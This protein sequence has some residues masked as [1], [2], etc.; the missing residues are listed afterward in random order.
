MKPLPTAAPASVAFV[1][2]FHAC[3]G[4]TGVLALADF[5][6][7]A[8]YDR[9]VGYYA[10]ARERIGRRAGTDFYTAATFQVFGALVAAG[11]TEIL[12]G[13]QAA[14]EHVFVEIG[15][16]PD[17]SVLAGATHDFAGVLTLRR[18]DE[19]RVPPR[20]IVFSNE[21]F[22]A[23]PFHRVVF[24]E[25]E[26]RELG[27]R[28]EGER[29]VWSELA[30]FS[31]PVSEVAHRLPA[32][33][34]EGYILDLPLRAEQ[35]AGAI[36]GQSWNGLFLAFD[37]GRTW[38]ELANEYPAGT[39]RAYVAHRQSGDLLREP[40]AQDLTCHVCWDWIERALR[41]AGFGATHRESQEAFF[42]RHAAGEI[43]RQWRSSGDPLSRARSQLKELL[44]PGLMGQRFEALWALR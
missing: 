13:P 30:E 19:L 37:Y 11:A 27:V 26:W 18:G 34:A 32:G 3:A 43:E 41:D 9:E 23:Q 8:L 16:E 38:R 36:A 22:D 42:V 10:A 12:G 35:L 2:R 44:H 5:F 17:R 28:W 14:R 25:G 6:E 15:G 40:G 21:L 24:R 4:A 20:A 29:F 7:L 33:A 1:R 31:P 39:A